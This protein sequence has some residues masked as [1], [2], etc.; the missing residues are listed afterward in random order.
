MSKVGENLKITPRRL[1]CLIGHVAGLHPSK[2]L[3]RC[4]MLWRPPQTVRRKSGIGDRTLSKKP[5]LLFYFSLQ[6]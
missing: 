3:G 1:I 6:L 2:N 5:L 4:G